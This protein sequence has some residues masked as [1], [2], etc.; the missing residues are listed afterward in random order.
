[1][2][3]IDVIKKLQ[4]NEGRIWILEK[5]RRLYIQY[6]HRSGTRLKD[7]CIRRIQVYKIWSR[8]I[9]ITYAVQSMKLGNRGV[10]HEMHKIACN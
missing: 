6:N 4:D 3:G 10:A 2:A 5:H 8:G 9:K 1:M 7:V